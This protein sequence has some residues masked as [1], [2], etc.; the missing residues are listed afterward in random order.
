MSEISLKKI[1]AITKTEYIKWI[2]NGRMYLLL[3]LWVFLNECVMEPLIARSEKME[4]PLNI[5]EPFLAI[6]NSGI[7]VLILPLIYLTLISDF[8]KVDGN[9]I[10]LLPRVGKRNWFLGQVL[11]AIASFHTILI[12]V[13]AGS[14]LPVAHCSFIYNGWSLVTTEYELRFPEEAGSYASELLQKNLYNQMPPWKAAILTYLFLGA[15]ML[16]LVLIMLLFQILKKK[17]FG[18][19]C[20]GALITFGTAFCGIHADAK[21]LFPMAHSLIWVHYND[22]E[23]KMVMP[24][25]YSVIYYAVWIAGLFIACV[26]GMRKINF[27]TIQE[28]D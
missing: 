10:F 14:I 25:R 21:W 5:L 16:L 17:I 19:F 18:F 22:Y 27:D 28:V 26:I 6:G 15:Y 4:T 8:P 24:I 20:C 1:W 11:F 12:L 9:T 23:R 13:L 3:I 2:C 7:V